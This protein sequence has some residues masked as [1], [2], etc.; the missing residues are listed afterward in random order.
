[1]LQGTVSSEILARFLFS[2]RFVK[3]NSQKGEI[4]LPF[5]DVGK[6]CS[7]REFLTSQACISTLLARE[8]IILPKISKF[9]VHVACF[10]FRIFCII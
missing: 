6:R 7:S 3:N 2:R 4:T 9:T 10:D 5:I 8:N 1:M